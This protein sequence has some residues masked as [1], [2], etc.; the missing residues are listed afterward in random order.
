MYIIILLKELLKMKKLLLLLTI[1]VTSGC[2]HTYVDDAFYK[3]YEAPFDTRPD[4]G[5]T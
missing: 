1:L 4:T 3:S 2:R 5:Y